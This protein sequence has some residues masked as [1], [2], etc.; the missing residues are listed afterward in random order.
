MAVKRFIVEFGTGIDM[1]GQDATKAATRAVEDAVSRSCL[2]GLVEILELEN[3]GEEMEVEVLVGVPEP[4][5]VN[6]DQVLKAVPFGKKRIQVV[7]GG[8]SAPGLYMEQLGDKSD[9]ILVA[10]AAVT[11]WV[12]GDRTTSKD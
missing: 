5:S 9:A 7:S 2:C 3:V 6:I 4:E 10:N 12:E 11:V 1:H 8:L